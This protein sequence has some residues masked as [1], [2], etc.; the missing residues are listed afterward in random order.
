MLEFPAAGRSRV[1]WMDAGVEFPMHGDTPMRRETKHRLDATGTTVVDASTCRLQPDTDV[2][3]FQP[4]V[5]T[6]AYLAARQINSNG[7]D[8]EPARLA[9]RFGAL[10][11]M[12]EEYGLLVGMEF[13][14]TTHI[15]TIG[16]ALELIVRSGASNAT[17]TV[18]ALHLARSG[19]CPADVADLE[20]DSVGY[21][22]LCDGPA[23][24][25]PGRYQWEAG[26]ER[27][28]PGDGDFPLVELVAASSPSTVIGAEVPS[29]S[30]L[31]RGMSPE[32]YAGLVRQS[33]L[34]VIEAARAQ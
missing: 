27:L 25:E 15:G 1:P 30:R 9:D 22:Q 33:L 23:R 29:H 19:G 34:S 4:M 28:L 2:E 14:A 32:H 18:D 17:I 7:D 6:A 13:Q 21:V 31:E 16:D 8:S 10:C 26:T 24:V 3:S 12:A 5:E 20:P 11:A